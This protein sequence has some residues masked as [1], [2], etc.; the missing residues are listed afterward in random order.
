MYVRIPVRRSRDT[1]TRP[2]W[3]QMLFHRTWTESHCSTGSDI[4]HINCTCY[5]TR[6]SIKTKIT[7]IMSP[8]TQ[9]PKHNWA[10]HII[11]LIG[12][13]AQS[14]V[15]LLIFDLERKTLQISYERSGRAC[16]FQVSWQPIQNTGYGS[17][18][19]SITSTRDLPHQ[20]YMGSTPSPVQ[21][22]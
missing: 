11:S 12:T 3:S 5:K 16:D 1:R 20:Q 15:M 14:T 2:E 8:V 22:I 7:R 9:C 13:M 6:N 19:H 4:K 17:E 10:V 18:E 21:Q